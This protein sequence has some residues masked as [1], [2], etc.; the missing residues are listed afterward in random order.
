MPKLYIE[1]EQTIETNPIYAFAGCSKTWIIRNSYG[2]IYTK[3]YIFQPYLFFKR[4]TPNWVMLY[5]T[6]IRKT[7]Y[8][9]GGDGVKLAGLWW[10]GA[11]AMRRG[12]GRPTAAMKMIRVL[13]LGFD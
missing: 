7:G 1:S 6:M 8:T 13:R 11:V 2:Y 10:V 4:E 5:T 3:I 9:L 12:A